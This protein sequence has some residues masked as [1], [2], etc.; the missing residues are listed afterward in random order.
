MYLLIFRMCT[1]VDN[2]I[3]VQVKVVKL[4]II[5]IRLAAVNRNLYTINFFRLKHKNIFLSYENRHF[6]T[7]PRMSLKSRT[8]VY[9]WEM[10]QLSMTFVTN[11]IASVQ[12]PTTFSMFYLTV[13]GFNSLHDG[14]FFSKSSFSKYSFRN[15]TLV[16]N[17]LDPDQTFSCAWSGSKLFAKVKELK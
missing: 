10:Q 13:S 17:S 2:T 12:S 16:S 11:K 6:R 5:R 1:G 15:T 9:N 7:M 3:H 8:I 14:Y 4:N